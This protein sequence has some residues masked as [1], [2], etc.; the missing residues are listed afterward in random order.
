MSAPNIVD[1]LRDAYGDKI[2]SGDVRGYCAAHGISY[3]TV[4]R[5]LD[6]YKV[7]RGTCVS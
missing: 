6:Q 7:S 3:P 5:K 1:A 4:T 2:T